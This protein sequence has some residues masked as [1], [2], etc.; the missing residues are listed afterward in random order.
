MKISLAFILATMMLFAN[1]GQ[2]KEVALSE[3]TVLAIQEQVLLPFFE[4]LKTGDI[5]VIKEH[6]SRDLYAKNRV[7]LD[8]NREYPS[9]LR[10]Y[11][12]DITFRILG[13][14][15]IFPGEAILFYV[16]FDYAG[17]NN[18]IH[19]LKLSRKQSGNQ[20][21]DVWVIEAF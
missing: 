6:M 10:D 9:F 5:I 20:P 21:G 15:E 7:L 13:A 4:A 14:E 1:P 8:E 19:E 18:S 12:K 16:S 11:Y 17:G 2:A 3:P